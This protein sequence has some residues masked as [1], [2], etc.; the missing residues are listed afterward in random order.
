MNKYILCLCL[1][2]FKNGSLEQ[3]LL[4]TISYNSRILFVENGLISKFSKT[5]NSI[6]CYCDET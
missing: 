6:N 5:H 2:D 1:Y 3:D 4:Q